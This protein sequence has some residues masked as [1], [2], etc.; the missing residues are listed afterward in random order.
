MSG[1]LL[2]A[3]SAQRA[4]TMQPDQIAA[5]LLPGAATSRR[6]F[7]SSDVLSLYTEIYENGSG[8]PPRRVD[9]TTRLID[10]ASR[11]VSV[12]RDVLTRG[13]SAANDKSATFAVS[14]EVPLRDVAPGRY[15]LRVEA[16]IRGETGESSSVA[17]ETTI[18]VVPE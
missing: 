2:T 4:F 9:V 5:K 15:L 7:T 17:R 1:L 13:A 14:K 11:E 18:R 10:E 16:Q 8:S 12:A 3:P 6:S